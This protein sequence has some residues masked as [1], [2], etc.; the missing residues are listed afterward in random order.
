MPERKPRPPAKLRGGLPDGEG[1]SPKI[2]LWTDGEDTNPDA[3]AVVRI[4]RRELLYDDEAGQWIATMQVRGIELSMDSGTQES[5]IETFERIRGERT[6]TQGTLD[7]DVRGDAVKAAALRDAI[8]RWATATNLGARQE[9]EKYFA[10]TDTS[11]A[12][13]GPGGG[14]E[15]AHLVEFCQ[16]HGIDSGVSDV[17]DRALNPVVRERKGR[18]R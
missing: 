1:L 17:T 16:H 10:P 3:F 8:A 15:L 12:P 13:V 18:T 14:A 4:N 6:H 7:M 9:W 11:K 2:K 5:L